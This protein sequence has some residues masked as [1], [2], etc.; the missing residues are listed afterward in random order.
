MYMYWCT[1]YTYD[2]ESRVRVRSSGGIPSWD[3]NPSYKTDSFLDSISTQPLAHP[4]MPQSVSVHWPLVALGEAC[5]CK[6]KLVVSRPRGL[7]SVC[8]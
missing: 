5:S 1:Y 6:R 3:G 7:C 4:I 8:V 2:W